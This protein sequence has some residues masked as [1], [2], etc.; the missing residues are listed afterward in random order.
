[1][2]TDNF[3]E[4]TV[5]GHFKAAKGEGHTHLVVFPCEMNNGVESCVIFSQQNLDN[6]TYFN[7]LILSGAL[8]FD[9]HK[10]FDQA[11]QGFD[12]VEASA[13]QLVFPGLIKPSQN[14]I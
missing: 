4:R 8:V 10:P 11:E 1:M 12:G 2:S 6:R 7:G 13:A 9:L 5:E 14:L 3:F